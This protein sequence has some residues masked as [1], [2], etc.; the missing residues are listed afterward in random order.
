[1]RLNNLLGSIALFLA[2]SASA[3]AVEPATG[4]AALADAAHP[5][6]RLYDASIDAKAAVDAALA[7]AA[8]RD[9]LVLIAMGANWCH[10]SRAFAGWT[11]TE[12]FG[13]LVSDHFELVFINVGHPQTADGHNLHIAERFGIE[14]ID[15]TPTV[16]VVAPDGTLLNGETART[17]RNAASRSEDEIFEELRNF[18]IAGSGS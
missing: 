5:E 12:R 1:M 13:Q 14:E 9:A 4:G 8:E 16:L 11:Q 3:G 17:W 7:R 18:A 10:D 6:A 15:G 2:V